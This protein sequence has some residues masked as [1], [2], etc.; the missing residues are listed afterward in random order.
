MPDL[1]EQQIQILQAIHK[2]L[3]VVAQRDQS[4][5]DVLKDQLKEVRMIL[6]GVD[7]SNGLRSV[8]KLHDADLADLKKWRTQ[9]M[10]VFTIIQLIGMPVL[11]FFFQH[12]IK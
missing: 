10:A 11:V 12:F 1:H 3:L 5:L 7:G 9:F 2:E 4:C 8:S 6:V